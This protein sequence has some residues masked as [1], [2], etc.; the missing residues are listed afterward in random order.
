M[1]FLVLRLLPCRRPC[2]HQWMLQ[3]SS[4]TQPGNTES[5]EKMIKR[6]VQ[7]LPV[8]M[9]NGVYPQ[10]DGSIAIAIKYGQEEELELGLLLKPETANELTGAFI[11]C[12]LSGYHGLASEPQEEQD[13]SV[14]SSQV[15]LTEAGVFEVT[16]QTEDGPSLTFRMGSHRARHIRDTLTALFVRYESRSR[17]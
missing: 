3:I 5:T 2:N 16:L 4:Y 10:E 8:E 11:E 12:P 6:T 17:Q 7:T 15:N 13:A 9:L 1:A 14:T